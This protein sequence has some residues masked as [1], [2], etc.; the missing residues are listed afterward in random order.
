MA[1]WRSS[2]NPIARSRGSTALS[3]EFL[4]Q[5]FRLE[6]LGLRARHLDE[7]DE[8]LLGAGA[9]DARIEKRL[10][11]GRIH[12]GSTNLRVMAVLVTATRV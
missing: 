6:A 11:V 1:S 12:R 7:R 4:E 5:R 2:E 3:D 8:Q 9:G 10:D